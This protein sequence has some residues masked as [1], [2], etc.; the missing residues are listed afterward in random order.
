[1]DPI[2]QEPTPWGNRHFCGAAWAASHSFGVA[3]R[4]GCARGSASTGGLLSRP[5][6]PAA[7]GGA[8]ATRLSAPRCAGKRRA[9]PWAPANSPPGL[10]RPAAGPVG[11]APGTGGVGGR[12]APTPRH[13][14]RPQVA[15]PS[16]AARNVHWPRALEGRFSLRGTGRERRPHTVKHSIGL[17]DGRREEKAGTTTRRQAFRH[18]RRRRFALA[19]EWGA[20]VPTPTGPAVGAR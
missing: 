13:R 4:G 8:P 1:M 20:A 10:P 19:A 17:R 12:A 11:P 18:E 9:C 16:T 14:A 6:G 3:D 7:G 5:I 2:G 15:D